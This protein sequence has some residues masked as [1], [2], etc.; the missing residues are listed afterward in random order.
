MF[1]SFKIVY[2]AVSR[3]IMSAS[4]STHSLKLM[5]SGTKSAACNLSQIPSALLS[6]SLAVC[7]SSN[8]EGAKR[9]FLKQF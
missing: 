6:D 1:A 5:F 7:S 2:Y 8:V 4:P 3:E 9:T